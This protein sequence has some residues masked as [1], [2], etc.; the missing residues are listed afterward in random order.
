MAETF[1]A[2][3]EISSQLKAIWKGL[4][5]RRETRHDW[6]KSIQVP[7][8]HEGQAVATTSVI[9]VR[10]QLVLNVERWYWY[11]KP[12]M[13]GISTGWQG[14][15]GLWNKVYADLAWVEARGLA[16][17]RPVDLRPV[18]PRKPPLPEWWYCVNMGPENTIFRKLNR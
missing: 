13:S 16:Q 9:V 10:A 3:P 7:Y 15:Q 17:Q 4:D 8:R 18:D 5:L 6:L 14:M 11:Y 1:R 12:E 2:M